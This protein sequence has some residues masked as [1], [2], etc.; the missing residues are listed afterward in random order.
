MAKGAQ[1]G[2][3]LAKSGR[4][5]EDLLKPAIARV[6]GLYL[7]H[8]GA[9]CRVIGS[10]A[11]PRGQRAPLVVFEGPA[12]LDFCGHYRG[13]GRMGLHCEIDAK[14]IAGDDKA[15]RWAAAMNPDQVVRCQ[16]LMVG[17]CLVGIALLHDATGKCYGLPWAVIDG[18]RRAGHMSIKL[19]DLDILAANGAIAD[20]RPN[21]GPVDLR[22]FIAMLANVAEARR[23]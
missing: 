7:G 18:Y 3:R 1:A 17:G 9:P 11:T 12:P 8:F 14:R 23:G 4:A 16:T 15:W 13:I 19:S 21:G 2:N 5:W 10:G 20:L 6:P 22:G